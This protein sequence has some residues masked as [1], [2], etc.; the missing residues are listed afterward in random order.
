MYSSSRAETGIETQP[1]TD[2]HIVLLKG[3]CRVLGR[4]LHAG[5]SVYVPAG[6]EHS[7]KAGV[8]GCTFVS[9]ESVNRAV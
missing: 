5:G 6:L 1:H 7:V 4:P 8:W 2:H 3:T 9:I